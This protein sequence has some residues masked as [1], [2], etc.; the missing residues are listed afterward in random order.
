LYNI[1]A[2]KLRQ[3]QGYALTSQ[4]FASDFRE[5]FKRVEHHW[6]NVELN[7]GP[8]TLMQGWIGSDDASFRTG[9]LKL[10]NQFLTVDHLIDN[11]LEKKKRG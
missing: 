4:Q 2:L 6:P 8:Q 3:L 10:A 11:L 5:Q 7:F 1:H 9:M